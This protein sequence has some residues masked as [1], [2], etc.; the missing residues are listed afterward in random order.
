MVFHVARQNTARAMGYQPA[1]AHMDLFTNRVNQRGDRVRVV[2]RG[3][4]HSGIFEL[5]A[6]GARHDCQTIAAILEAWVPLA[7]FLRVARS[8]VIFLTDPRG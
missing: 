5:N 6:Y 1:P 8:E 3:N 4:D 7:R 2:W